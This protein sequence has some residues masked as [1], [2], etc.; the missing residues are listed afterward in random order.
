MLQTRL[1]LLALRLMTG[2]TGYSSWN[3]ICPGRRATWGDWRVNFNGPAALIQGG[4][5]V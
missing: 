5:L 1:K 3:T 2:V 4:M